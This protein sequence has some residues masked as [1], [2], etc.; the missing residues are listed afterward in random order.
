MKII[1]NNCYSAANRSVANDDSTYPVIF[2]E[3]KDV[4]C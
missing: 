1:I 4:W 2:N 3:L